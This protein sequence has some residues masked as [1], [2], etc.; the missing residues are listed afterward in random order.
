[1][2]KSSSYIDEQRRQYS[3]YVMQMRAIPAASDGLKSAARRVLWTGRDGAKY[4]SSVLAA[5]A[6]PLHPHATPEG[7]V[8]TLAARYGNNIPLL[9]PYGMFGTLLKP[10]DFGAS[11][12][13]SV[14]ISKFTK[15]VVFRD[16][17]IV[18][19]Q[20][21]YDGTLLEPVHFLPLVPIALLNPSEGIAIGFATNILPRSLEDLIVLQLT[22]LSGAKD[23]KEPYPKFKPTAAPKPFLSVA[24]KREETER[25]V[26]YYFEGSFEKIDATTIRINKLPYGLMHD[27]LL[28]KL[29]DLYEKGIILNYTDHSKDIIDIIVKFKKGELSSRTDDETLHLVGLAI[30]H[31]ENLNVVD[32]TGKAILNTDPVAFIRLFTDWR[33]QWYVQRYERLRDLLQAELQRHY[34]VRIA[35]KHKASTTAAKCD[36]RAEL[37]EWLDAIKIV[38]VDYIADLPVYRF[39]EEERLKNEEKIKEG[40]TQLKVYLDLLS[41]EAKRRKVY[42]SELEEVL[43]NYSKG[44][45]KNE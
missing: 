1:M 34:D 18:P 31:I 4:K 38:N 35:I 13:T 43:K 36:S 7:A 5:S 22:H 20:E 16:I 15:E 23:L 40:E 8:N 29:D 2:S 17:E 12:Y 28:N 44:L 3:L 33:L 27:K 30:R 19:M 25:G 21:N 9:T 26:A 10:T 11:R 42:I 39:T 24:S 37:K 6:V 32:F 45:Y 14:Q 41:S